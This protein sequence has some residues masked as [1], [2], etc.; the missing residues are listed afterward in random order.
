M[1]TVGVVFPACTVFHAC[2]LV[3]RAGRRDL[4]LL[5]DGMVRDGF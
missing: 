1:W 4:V 3:S 5:E 2:E